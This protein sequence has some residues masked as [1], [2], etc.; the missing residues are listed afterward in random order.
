MFLQ[1][2]PLLVGNIQEK[3]LKEMWDNSMAFS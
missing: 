2:R 1:E 3:T